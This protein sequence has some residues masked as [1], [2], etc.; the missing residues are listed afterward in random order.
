MSWETHQTTLLKS[1]AP[2]FVNQRKFSAKRAE[3]DQ[4]ERKNW[5]IN[6]YWAIQWKTAENCD[7]TAENWDSIVKNWDLTAENWEP[8]AKNREPTVKNWK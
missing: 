7:S 1:E 3:K 5:D 8:T 6:R 2:F 4:I